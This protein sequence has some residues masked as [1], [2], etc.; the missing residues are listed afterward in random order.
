MG[1]YGGQ[2]EVNKGIKYAI[3]N[4]FNFVCLLNNDN[5]VRED[6]IDNLLNTYEKKSKLHTLLL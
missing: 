6:I 2:E 1:I 4:N 5:I 3:E